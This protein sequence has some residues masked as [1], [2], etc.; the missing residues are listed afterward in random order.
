M[1]A[2]LLAGA[3]AGFGQALQHNAQTSLEQKRQEALL[4]IRNKY[5]SDQADTKWEREQG[6]AAAAAQREERHRMEER[7]WALQDS[8]RGHHQAVELANVRNSGLL[9]AARIRSTPQGGSGDEELSRT[10]I[11]TLISQLESERESEMARLRRERPDA[12]RADIS[13][14]L[15]DYDNQIMELRRR[16]PGG[17]MAFGSNE[18]SAGG[19]YDWSRFLD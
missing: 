4:Q 1:A 19:S 18:S 17:T 13:R 9:D 14:A 10:D 5:A 12:T 16:L 11:T 7:E 15:S 8:E 6:A 2:G 3:M